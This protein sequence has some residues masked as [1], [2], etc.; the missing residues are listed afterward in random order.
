MDPSTGKIDISILTTGISG[1][2]RK[3]RAERAQALKTII[4]EK[5]KAPTLRYNKL[6]EEFKERADSVSELGRYLNTCRAE[7]MSTPSHYLNQCWNIVNPN[8]G[9]KLQWNSYLLI[10]E[11]AFE[12]IVCE[13][14]TI[15]PLPQCVKKARH[16]IVLA[17]VI[18]EYLFFFSS[19]S[20]VRCLTMLFMTWKM[21]ERSS[22]L[23][24]SCDPPTSNIHN[25][26]HFAMYHVIGLAINCC[27]FCTLV[28]EILLFIAQ[29]RITM[30]VPQISS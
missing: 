9:N 6:L 23:V 20:P 14:A 11:N 19:S 22:A 25:N 2:A 24:P 3:Q 16:C 28:F 10:Q 30:Y 29:P 5:G 4:R 7:F 8:C 17:L 13:M 21:T 18:T 1:A 27:I 12:N 26:L 15:L